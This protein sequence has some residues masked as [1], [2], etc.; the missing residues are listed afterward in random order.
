[1]VKLTVKNV[2][3][4]VDEK[5]IPCIKSF[6]SQVAADMAVAVME[7]VEEDTVAAVEVVD[8]EAEEDIEI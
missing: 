3:S 8:M 6:L 5:P 4:C 2:H 1:M 7:V